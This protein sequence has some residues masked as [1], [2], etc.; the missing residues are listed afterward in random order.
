MLEVER[1]QN[2]RQDGKMRIYLMNNKSVKI[3]NS[4]IIQ[5]H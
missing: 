2:K 3:N 1:T 5:F 4:F